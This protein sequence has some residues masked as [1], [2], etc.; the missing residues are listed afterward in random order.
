MEWLKKLIHKIKCFLG[1]CCNKG[2]CDCH[3]HDK[4]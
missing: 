1:S 4:K 3:D 2:G